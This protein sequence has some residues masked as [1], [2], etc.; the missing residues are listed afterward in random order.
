MVWT[1]YI[2]ALSD[3]RFKGSMPLEDLQKKLKNVR[4]TFIIPIA[5]GWTT[6]KYIEMIHAGVIPFFHP[7]Y[8]A[9]DNLKVPGWLRPKNPEELE[10]AIEA[11]QNERIYNSA[12]RTLQDMFCTPEYYDGTRLNDI[13]MRNIDPNYSAPDLSKYETKVVETFDL[14]NFF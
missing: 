12:I 9:Q 1:W 14:T 10:G 2:R 3:E 13:V 6:S 11:L 4:S 7:S 5:P 8:D